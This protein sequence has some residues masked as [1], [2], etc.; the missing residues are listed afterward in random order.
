MSV[1][2]E[3]WR[4]VGMLVR[5]EKFARELYEEM[6]LH[7]EMKERELI[8]S[9]TKNDEARYAASRSFGNATSLSE[10]GREAWGWRRLEDFAQDLRFGVR[11]LR[12]NPGFTLTAVLTLALG[13]GANTAVFSVIEAVLLRPLPYKDS[14]HLVVL[15]DARDPIGGAFSYRELE[16]L[17][18]QSQSLEDLAIYY[19]DT[20]FSRVRLTDGEPELIQAGFVSANF[21]PMMGVAPM[22]GRSF[23]REEERRQEHVVVL[24]YGL[25][26]RRF[27]RAPDA[28][29]KTLEINGARSQIIGVM[30]ASFQF[31]ARDQ[32]F[33][34]P[35]TTNP[36]WNDPD[37]TSDSDS[38]HTRAFYA[39][40]QAAGRL[41]AWVTRQQAQ[42]ELNEIFAHLGNT[43]LNRNAVDVAMLRVD[44]SD[45]TRLVF[46]VLLGA[47]CAVLLIACSNVA[48][49]MLAR[50]A[51]RNREMAVRAALGAGI[52]RLT[53]QLLSESALLAVF[54]AGL[55]LVFAATGTRVLVTL[56]PAEIPRL[57]QTRVDAGVL[58]FAI[59]I[60][61]VSVILFG[62]VPAVKISRGDPNDSLKSG[63][64]TASDSAAVKRTR[65]ALVVAEFAIAVVLVIGTGLLVRS[66]LAVE[67]LDPGFAPEHALTLRVTPMPGL[68]TELN[69]AYERILQRIEALPGVEAAGAIDNLFQLGNLGNLGLRVVEGRAP[70]TSD[71]WKPLTW[72]V[73]R[74]NYMQA[75]SAPLI[76][77]R[78]FSRQDG[79]T[80][81][82]VAIIDQSMAR[83]YWPTES[84]IGKRFKGQDPRGRNDA[85][86]EVVGVVHDMRRNGLERNPIPHVY[87]WNQQTDEV[88]KTAEFVVKTS[89]DPRALAGSLRAT[90]RG[91]APAAVLS[92]VEPLEQRL[93]SQLS[94]RRFQTWL[95]GVFSWLAMVLAGVGI[96]GVMAYSVVQRTP[97]IGIRVALGAQRQAVMWLILV[98][99]G[100]LALIG[101]GIGALVALALMRWM[102]SLLFGVTATDPMTFV[103]TAGLLCVVGLMACYVP[104]R[105]AMRVDPMVALRHE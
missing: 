81:P 21:L 11:M 92:S 19:R 34:A 13:I 28:I 51:A 44:V 60:A 7:R 14:A 84:A 91:A 47:V 2:G 46:L 29:G 66:L 24:S 58:A 72:N 10:R 71:Q 26:T 86:I 64:R 97:E 61:A 102:Q 31:P 52:G 41:K 95:L 32:Q 20:G 39:R 104:A 78:Y 103:A 8:A 80:A 1:I 90:V 17:K 100:G 59:G 53:R 40:W 30:P 76:A 5:Q 65:S 6:R 105:R 25:W 101:V 63:S 85:W 3:F 23:T 45:R 79:P 12:N 48:N 83:R 89:G 69:G 94:M 27:G 62:L 88:E 99:G 93:S 4:R 42:E 38:R 68:S 18:T 57:E 96:F 49:L 56:G 82:L 22:L 43:N 74:G 15:T 35:V 77:G 67:A 37:L 98:R 75:M 50:G 54:S 87:L 33:W 36:W 73:I 70:E 9:G 16:I 55:G